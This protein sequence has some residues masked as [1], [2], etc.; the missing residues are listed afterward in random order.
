MGSKI[1][2]KSGESLADV[3]DVEGSVAGL[4]RLESEDVHVVHEMGGAI[5]SERAG[6]RVIQLQSGAIAQNIQFNVNLTL[7]LNAV[8]ILH[9]A[10]IADVTARTQALILSL[11]DVVGGVISTDCPFFAWVNG[12][13]GD[14]DK[15]I[16]WMQ[17]GVVL[18]VRYFDTNSNLRAMPTMAMG[19]QQAPNVVNQLTLRGQTSGFGAGTVSYT[20]VV[21]IAFA[22]VGGLSSKGLPIPSW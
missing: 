13:A 7:G 16:R 3:Y 2:S 8:R 14:L 19:E 20:A 15:P 22:E 9:Y 5:F 17:N 11:S 12:T 10:M 1:L 6:A 21:L 4:E 18:N